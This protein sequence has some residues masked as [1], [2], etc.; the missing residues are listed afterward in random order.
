MME[1]NTTSATAPLFAL[2]YSSY[3]TEGTDA[4]SLEVILEQ[5][6]QKNARLEITGI[7]LYRR[8]RFYQYLEG[9]EEAVRGVYDEIQHDSRHTHLR[10]L[11]ETSVPSRR[12]SEWKMGYEPLRETTENTPAGFRSTFVDLEDTQNPANVLRAVTELTYWYRAR[13]SRAQ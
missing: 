6:R 9:T 7:L 13:A 1:E 11:L 3:A 10:I 5:A 12:F 4:I 8:G 2:M